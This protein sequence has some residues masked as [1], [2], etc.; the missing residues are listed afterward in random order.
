MQRFIIG[1]AAGIVILGGARF[2]FSP[3]QE[4]PHYHANWA[5][6]V[7]GERLDLSDDRYMEDTSVCVAG[8]DV[9]AAQRVHMHEG[10]DDV[11]HVHHTGVTW[12]H[13]LSV[14]GFGLGADYLITADGRRLFDGADGRTI[15]FVVNGFVVPEIHN[16]VIQ[17]GDRVLI[18]YGPE[19]T[20]RVLEEQ[21]P[22]VASNAEEYNARYDPAGCSGAARPSLFD[23]LR[24]AFWG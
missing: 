23:R 14:L 15:K 24:R 8:D 4:P 22:R 6:F 12:G 19:S 9:Q 10:V 18:S 21:F 13:F 2:A 20:D 11:V 1:L 3:W 7:D 16:R 17:S 5:V